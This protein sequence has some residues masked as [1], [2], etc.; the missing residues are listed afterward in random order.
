MYLKKG[1]KSAFTLVELMV[2]LLVSG[3][4][5]SITASTYGLF[6]KSISRDQVRA[7]L[8]QN[9]RISLDRLS[10]ELRQTPDIL[11]ILPV[12]L[13]DTS[14]TQPGEIEF[15]DGHSNDL[16]YRRYYVD[17]HTLKL[18]LKE[19]YFSYQTDVR[20]HWNSMGNGGVSPIV[21]VISTVD[22]ADNVESIAFYGEDQIW[23]YMTTSDTQGQVYNLRTLISARNM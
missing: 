5:I 22:V 16:S 21:R 20:V 11:T 8:N 18:D 6:R 1:R 3:I 2:A 9:A 10:R 7:D 19:Y 14:V 4:L 13:D 17:N 15:E 23:I 12:D